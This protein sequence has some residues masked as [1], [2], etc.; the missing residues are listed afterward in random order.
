MR[1]VVIESPYAGD[2]QRNTEYA[3]LCLKDSLNRG[4]SPIASHLLLTQVLDD[5]IPEE[6]ELGIN[7][8]LHWTDVA[9]AHIFYVDY[10]LSAGMMQALDRTTS[11]LNSQ[12]NLIL[13]HA[14]DYEQVTINPRIQIEFRKILSNNCPPV[15]TGDNKLNQP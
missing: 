11:F 6:R 12:Y 1:K 15:I 7:A 3:R 4:E 2:V 8:G 5:T 14:N 13:H 10:G 9:D